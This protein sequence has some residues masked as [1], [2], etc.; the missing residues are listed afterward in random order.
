MVFC[1]LYTTMLAGRG[2]GDALVLMFFGIIPVCVTFFIQT[3]TVTLPTALLALGMGL[4]TDCLLV[5]NNYRDREQDELA[6]KRTLVVAIGRQKAEVLYLGLG[7]TAVALPLIGTFTPWQLLMLPYLFLH[8]RTWLQMC[9][10]RQ[11][12]ALNNVLGQTA[13]CIFLYA[14]LQS[15]VLVMASFLHA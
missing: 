1:F 12:R 8:T 7:Y 14:L 3:H 4:A 5:V 15:V 11:G 13:G 6:G 10:I 9:R 2:L